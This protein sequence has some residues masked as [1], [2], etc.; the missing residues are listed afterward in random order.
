MPDEP[1]PRQRV[2]R[3]L[4]HESVDRVPTDFWAEP[5][6][7][8]N[9]KA[10]FKTESKSEV[11]RQLEVDI[12][13]V[14]PTYV[15]PPPKVYPDGSITNE[16]GMR[17]RIT[18]TDFG[19]EIVDF[20]EPPLRQA[21][22]AAE[23]AAHPWPS[24]DWWDVSD[25]QQKIDTINCDNEYFIRC[26]I[27]S[28]LEST[29]ALRGFEQT[30]LDLGQ[31]SLIPGLIFD[32]LTQK[33]IEIGEMI[34]DAAGGR[35]DAIF[36]WDDFGG[37]Q[38]LLMSPTLI[39]RELVPRHRRIIDAFHKYGTRVFFHSDGAVYPLL[40]DFINMGVD[41]LNPLQSRA[42][43]MDLPKIKQLFGDKLGFHGAIDIQQTLPFGT[44]EDVQAEVRNR[45]EVLG[46]NGGYILCPEHYLQPDTPMENIVAL[47]DPAL[48]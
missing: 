7:W 19:S 17:K 20:V 34:L 45:V 30:F 43:G 9:L 3:T 42:K 22:S 47:Y 35:I 16:W 32:H 24:A 12:R 8:E 37:Q 39:R 28:I 23:V 36:T 6:T 29:W 2:L 25:L 38:N 4:A 31:G 26:H 13:T 18:L 10:H 15:G 44:I 11:L 41:V 5:K 46:R 1:T 33:L 21:S 40:N 48:R 14:T 27:G